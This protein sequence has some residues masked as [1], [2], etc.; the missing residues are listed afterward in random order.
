MKI[1]DRVKKLFADKRIRFLFVGGLNTAVGYGFYALFIFIGL[2]PYLATTLS[3]IL[4]VINSYFWNKY[5]TFR[6]PKKSLA[7]VMRFALVYG[8]SYGANLG[9]VYIFIDMLGMN[10]YVSGA[11]CL[12]VTTIV[13][14]VGHNFFSF[15]SKSNKEAS[16]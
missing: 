13:S 14:Y 10:S 1:V 6:Q 11:V 7:E 15:K 4:G 12:F 8:I 3:T 2:D 16:I 5:F 9:L